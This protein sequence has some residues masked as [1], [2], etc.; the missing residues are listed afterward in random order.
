MGLL[1]LVTPGFP[2][3]ALAAACSL[4]LLLCSHGWAG[5]AGGSG[6][7]PEKWRD[8]YDDAL[9]L[10]RQQ[11][12]AEASALLEGVV[13]ADRATGGHLSLL[14]WCYV[15]RE[16]YGPAV[17]TL[18]R[19]L[20]LTPGSLEAGQALAVALAGSGKGREAIDLATRLADEHPDD[21]GTLA[22][23]RRVLGSAR[24]ASDE[25]LR[26]AESRPSSSAE[27]VAR[28]GR[29]YLEVRG[30]DGFHPLFIKGVNMGVALPGRFP[31]EFP[32]ESALYREWFDQIAAGGFNVVRTYTLLPP[33]F[34]EMLREHNDRA[35]REA[36]GSAAPARFIWLIQ[37]VWTELPDGDR[38]DDPAFMGA[39]TE[40]MER[41]VDVLHGN[42]LVAP[43]P[44]HASGLY[45]AEVS[46]MTLAFILGR[47]WEP[48]SVA[49]YDEMKKGASFSGKYFHTRGATAMEAWVAATM[50]HI[51]G[52]EARAYGAMRPVAFTNWPTL[53]P[54]HHPTEATKEEE[55]ELAGRLKLPF[56]ASRVREY[57][58]DGSSVDAS[59]IIPTARAAAGHFASYH[60]YPYYPD[61]MNLDPGYLKAADHQG[62]NNYIG[63]LRELRRHH[64]GLPVL[65]SEIGVPTSRGIAH[66][67]P[68]GMNHG[69]HNEREQGEIDARLMENIHE[70]GCAGGVIFAW[71]DE[72]F[73]KNWAVIEFELPA[74]RNPMWHNMLD[75]EQNYG[76]LAMRPGSPGPAVVLDGRPDD[77][78]GR[79]PLLQAGPPAGNLGPQAPALR[80]LWAFHDEAAFYFRVDADGLDADGDGGIDWE[81]FSVMVGIDTYGSEKGDRRFPTRE[82]VEAPTGMEFMVILD[83]DES[84]RIL[85]DPPYDLQSHRYN[86]PYRSVPNADGRY[87]EI[88]TLTN[89]A[90]VGR[91]GTLY[92]PVDHS[93]SPLRLGTTDPSASGYDDLSDWFYDGEAGIIEVRIPWGL[94]NVTDPSSHHVVEDGA[95]IE[96]GVGITTTEGFRLYAALEDSSA[97]RVLGTLPARD[98]AGW[99]DSTV[100]TLYSWPGWEEPSWHSRPKLSY[101]ILRD[102]MA[103]L[104]TWIAP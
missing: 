81:R 65:I 96:G 79:A 64:E 41:I 34:Y 15:H 27:V 85:V 58:N 103:I 32:M 14:G 9:A 88:R 26:P 93:R 18:R 13:T 71:I 50:E 49:A 75:P 45:R 38:Y 61:F 89:R 30:A 98:G 102:R 37:G 7:P 4:A 63:Y 104:P 87:M 68:Q 10:F 46:G 95:D 59:L 12:W 11:K 97:G 53:D 33:V 24:L 8:P 6:K 3:S 82:R 19:S 73:K 21:E 22:V 23:L 56:D 44:G 78:H 40:E 20:E 80:A 5:A 67:Q 72:W 77:W 55:R 66:I 1:P 70:T 74:E 16:L 69:G 91:D 2:S 94:L 52:Y 57:D 90:R 84:S 48:F 39:F 86:R 99:M 25:R 54:L 28:A 83:G 47:E 100:S 29:D 17:E 35:T 76:L 101:F 92:P 31:A 43:R 60:A 42:I 51:V 62:P 36:S